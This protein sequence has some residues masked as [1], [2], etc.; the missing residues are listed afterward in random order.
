MR[1]LIIL[2]TAL[3][4]IAV[5]GQDKSV[6]KELNRID[7]FFN[8]P[9]VTADTCG[10]TQDTIE[11]K[12]F[13]N[14]EYDLLYDVQCK[15]QEI[16]G[17]GVNTISLQGR[18]FSNDAW[19][20]ITSITYYGGGTDTTVNFTQHT[21]ASVV[22]YNHLRVYITKANSLG[23]TKLVYISGALKHN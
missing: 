19:T 18:K 14:K 22:P 13:V 17:R 2:L 8:Y 23:A 10:V 5:N 15:V 7:C 1:K 11:Y 20:N 3:V 9:G 16:R 4:A 21:I 6:S 12:W